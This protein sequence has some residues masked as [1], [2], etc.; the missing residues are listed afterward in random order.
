LR[1]CIRFAESIEMLYRPGGRIE[2][3]QFSVSA[4]EVSTDEGA[5]DA[6]NALV[7]YGVSP[8]RQIA[9]DGQILR[10]LAALTDQVAD[11]ILTRADGQWKVQAFV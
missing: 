3:G 11:L 8:T 4:V 10:D 7:T 6:T 9:A 1:D 5:D 2:G